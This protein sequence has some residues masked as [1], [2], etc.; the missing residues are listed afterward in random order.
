MYRMCNGSSGV[1]PDDYR[2]RYEIK[3][4]IRCVS[5][6]ISEINETL[7]IREF[8]SDIFDEESCED[9][10][11]KAENV[12]ELLKYAEEALMELRS[13]S[14]RLDELRAELIWSADMCLSYERG[15][16]LL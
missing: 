4:D 2:S 13:L 7:N 1:G 15:D 14:E 10:V 3:E 16:G 6:R 8:I 5:E 11:K 12:T 9:V